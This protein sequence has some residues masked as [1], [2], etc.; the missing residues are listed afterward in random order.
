M[1]RKTKA[2]APSRIRG[3]IVE[4]AGDLNAAGLMSDGDLQKITMRMLNK[5]KLPKV[6]ALTGPEIR[7]MRERAGLSQAVFAHY[8]NLTVSYV[9]QLER[10]EKHPRGATAKLLDVIRRNGFEAIM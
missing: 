4:M 8:L 9:S 7:R 6:E 3:E 1:T 10:G 2:R 5:N